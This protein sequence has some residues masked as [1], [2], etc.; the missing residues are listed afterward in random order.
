MI[1]DFNNCRLLVTTTAFGKDNPDIR[2]Y[3]EEQVNEV[4]YNSSSQPYMS[5]A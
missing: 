2:S 5:V 4:I 1:V 3:L